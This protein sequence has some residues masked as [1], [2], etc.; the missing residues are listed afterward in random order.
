MSKIT[1]DVKETASLVGVST[2]SIY[3]MV[4]EKQIPFVQVRKRIL[5]HREKIESWLRGEAG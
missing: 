2:D 1:L 3:K 5:F 4:R